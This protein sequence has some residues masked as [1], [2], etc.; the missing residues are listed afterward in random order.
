M[1]V[2]ETQHVEPGWP[3]LPPRR[4]PSQR[5]VSPA[6]AMQCPPKDGRGSSRLTLHTCFVCDVNMLEAP[7]NVASWDLETPGICGTCDPSPGDA[8][9]P[10]VP[11]PPHVH[12]GV[13][14]ERPVLMAAIGCP[15]ARSGCL[16]SVW[17]SWRWVWV[18]PSPLCFM[19]CGHSGVGPREAFWGRDHPGTGFLAGPS[20]DRPRGSR[21]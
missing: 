2:R 3:G 16:G 19:P 9:H 7:R 1:Y 8:C 13:R 15:C 12:R 5:L 6:V 10:A 21:G 14:Q 11:C 18:R 17:G 4:T 20:L